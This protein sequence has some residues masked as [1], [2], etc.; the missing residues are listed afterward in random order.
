MLAKLKRFAQ[1]TLLVVAGL[2][3]A[4]LFAPWVCGREA[5]A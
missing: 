5:S 3:T 4:R 1:R 2:S